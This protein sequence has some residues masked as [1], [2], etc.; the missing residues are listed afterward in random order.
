MNTPVLYPMQLSP[1]CKSTIWG[2]NRMRDCFGFQTKLDNIAE[3]WMMSARDDNPG[4]I[5]N[6]EYMAQRIDK[7][8]E[9]YPELLAK[10]NTDPACPLLIKFIDARDKL[11]IQVHPDD[12]Y[13]QAAGCADPR[14][15]TEMWIVLEAAMGAELIF[16]TNRDFTQDEL[17]SAIENST[18]EDLMNYVPVKAGD[19]FFIPAGL[20]HAIG[21]GI[22]IAEIQQNCDTTYRVY[23]YN[24]RQ[25]DGSLRA[26]HIDDAVACSRH[27]T[28]EEVEALQ[29][30]HGNNDSHCLADSKYFHVE[31]H[32]VRAE[33]TFTVGDD[34]FVSVL[35]LNGQGVLSC[36]GE[37]YALSSG[38]SYF[39]PAGM[40]DYT[41]KGEGG[42]V[43]IILSRT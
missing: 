4:F 40:G 43:N 34:S 35:V 31:Q 18:L 29:Y 25:S 5:I 24:R 1:V 6:G 13:A 42:S 39:L 10:G 28:D 37:N 19:V 41:V 11:S 17:R 3:A 12:A 8:I 26:L 21:S 14:G 36:N 20:I 2:G 15:K 9:E 23:D 38:V 7:L 33:T 30:V 27:F 16:G 32:T 22:L